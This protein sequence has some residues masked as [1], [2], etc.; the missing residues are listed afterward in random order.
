MCWSASVSYW[1]SLLQAVC[2]LYAV[3]RGRRCDVL[4]AAA[5]LPVLAQE[6]IS[7]LLWLDIA[8]FPDTDATH[9][10]PRN[11]YLSFALT[12]CVNALPL[13]YMLWAW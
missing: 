13:V 4:A 11:R 1:F 9:C 8:E 2:L 7:C 5:H 6:F 12:I 3:W 10:S